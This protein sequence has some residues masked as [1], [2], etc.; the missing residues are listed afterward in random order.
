MIIL[1]A[2]IFSRSV[3][4][5][6]DKVRDFFCWIVI[7]HKGNIAI[8]A[9]RKQEILP[10]QRG[11]FPLVTEFSIE[12]QQAVGS[13]ARILRHDCDC[14]VTGWISGQSVL[15]VTG[16]TTGL[17]LCIETFSCWW[18]HCTVFVC[19]PLASYTAHTKQRANRR[20]NTT[21]LFPIWHK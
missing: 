4:R 14:C 18:W 3:R 16:C 2:T 6:Q 7:S 21:K 5:K 19:L 10:G 15:A 12:T 11:C 17:V 13:L 9:N 8:S 20:K 1:I